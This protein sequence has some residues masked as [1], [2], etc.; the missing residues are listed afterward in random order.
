MIKNSFLGLSDYMIS[1]LVNIN[2]DNA[3]EGI[4][5]R[6]KGRKDG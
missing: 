6:L 4:K 3:M 5:G 2:N 1:K